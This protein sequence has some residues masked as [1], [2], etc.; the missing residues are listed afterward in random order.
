MFGLGTWEIILILVVALIFIGPDKL[1]KVAKS[2]GQGMRKVRS[3]MDQVDAEIHRAQDSVYESAKE[4]TRDVEGDAEG[5]RERDPEV[6][7]V[8]AGPDAGA[9][10]MPDNLTAN[11]PPVRPDEAGPDAPSVDVPEP[12]APEP[13]EEIAVSPKSPHWRPRAGPSPEG[14]VPAA[15][16]TGPTQDARSEPLAGAPPSVDGA[17]E[18]RGPAARPTG[19]TQDARSRPPGGAPPPVDGAPDPESSKA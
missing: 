7:A 5:A 10:P 13:V 4:A 12:G 3:A 18:G 6:G 9:P 2:I 8:S 16:P 19:P 11:R 1:P 14:R 17:S 15:R